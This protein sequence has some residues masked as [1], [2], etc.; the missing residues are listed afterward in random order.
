MRNV[1]KPLILAAL[2]VAALT[3]M[4]PAA[5][6]QLEEAHETL[7]LRSETTGNH[8]PVVTPT[9]GG[10]L[11]HATSEGAVELRKHVFGIE[12]HITTCNV[13]AW[14]RTNEDAEGY[15]LHHK[16]TGAGCTRQPCDGDGNG[17]D[18]WHGHGD[19]T[20]LEGTAPIEGDE[21]VEIV[22]CVEPAGGV[23]ESCELEVPVNETAT[24]HQYEFGHS[25]LPGHG[26]SGFRCEPIGHWQTE[27]TEGFLEN[28]SNL[29]KENIIEAVHL[30]TAAKPEVP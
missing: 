19:E 7:E 3:T 2:A 25:E 26:V 18:L 6:G 23:D 5:F 22:L 20:T 11:V 8:C 10:C 21:K 28:N 24:N 1:C 29:Q 17:P 13:E 30:P 12:S 14:G 27:Q 4:A 16:L 15:V 9:A